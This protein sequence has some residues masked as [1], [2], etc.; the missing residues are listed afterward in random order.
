MPGG[1]VDRVADVLAIF[2][3]GEAVLG[4]E[5]R[6]DVDTRGAHHIDIALAQPVHAGLVG[7]QPDA[8]IP[9]EAGN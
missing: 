7:D 3:A 1:F 9:A 4:R 2:D 8:F 5:E 6:R